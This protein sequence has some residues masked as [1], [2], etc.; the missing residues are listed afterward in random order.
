MSA[1]SQ[2]R[3][4]TYVSIIV[5][6]II[7][8]IGIPTFLWLYKAP[9]CTDRIQNGNEQGVDC[10]GSCPRLC[11]SAFLTPSVAWTRFEKVTDGL[12]NVSAYIVNP[13]IDAGANN[14]PYHIALYDKEGVL[15]VDKTGF[16]T[17]PPH[18]NSLAFLPA[19]STGKRVPAKALFEFA[20][21]PNWRKKQDTLTK[22]I[23]KDKKYIEEN[24]GSSLSV[25]LENPTVNP[26]GK[27]SVFA[28]LYDKDGNAIGFSKTIIDTIKPKS[29]VLAPF[30]WPIVRGKDRVISIEVLP[31]AE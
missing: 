27:M 16:M 30:T 24:Y 22:L 20:A 29:S 23:I 25:T 15:I 8:V 17:I 5:I 9:T 1:W 4:F 2:K 28:V 10:G 11:A 21:I 18:R 14:V 13:N 19:V 31:V 3:K 6:F 12:Y 26:I 7:V